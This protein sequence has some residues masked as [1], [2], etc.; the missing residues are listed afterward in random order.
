MSQTELSSDAIVSILFA[1]TAHLSEDDIEK[2]VYISGVEAMRQF[3]T[4]RDLMTDSL[5]ELMS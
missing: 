3:I 2:V 1:L 5:A 4:E